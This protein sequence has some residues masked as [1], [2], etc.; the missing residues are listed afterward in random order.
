MITKGGD[1]N[2]LKWALFYLV[3][4]SDANV[5]KAGPN[6]VFNIGKLIGKQVELNE[7]EINERTIDINFSTPRNIEYNISITVPEGKT[8]KGLDGLNMS[9][10]NEIGEF[11]STA[12]QVGNVINVKTVKKYKNNSF[13][14]SEWSKMVAFLEAGFQFTEKKVILK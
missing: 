9:I 7:D 8:A 4:T 10:V 3:F 5:N 11:V 13:R 1:N 12:G 6:L 2:I 14:A